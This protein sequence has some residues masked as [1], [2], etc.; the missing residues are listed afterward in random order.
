MTKEKPT[1]HNGARMLEYLKGEREIDKYKNRYDA[2]NDYVN[3][4]RQ[5]YDD[6]DVV[7]ITLKGIKYF[8]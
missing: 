8:D 6:N 2:Y 3:Q 7:E 4:V 5:S 1:T